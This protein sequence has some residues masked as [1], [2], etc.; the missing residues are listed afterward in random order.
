[1]K[2][3][4]HHKTALAMIAGGIMLVVP[5]CLPAL[6]APLPAQPTPQSYELPA[7]FNGANELENSA[8]LPA[9]EFFTDPHLASLIDQA[10]GGNLQLKIL[11]EDVAIANN[12][13]LRRRGAYLPL[14]SIGTSASFRKLSLYT[15][16]G[17]DVYS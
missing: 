16:E 15:L 8:T 11:F 9:R 7:S 1:M 6:R 3:T 14:F 2:F 17:S 10:L 13:I 5:G 12:E 4:K